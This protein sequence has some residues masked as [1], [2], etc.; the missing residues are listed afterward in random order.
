M[1][2]MMPLLVAPTEIAQ[3]L[4]ET[5]VRLRFWLDSL[6]PNHRAGD[7][8]MSA[9]ESSSRETFAPELCAASP[10]QMAGLLS[11]LMR[12]GEA[13]RVL[14]P[15]ADEPLEEEL[16]EYRENVEQLRALMPFI[17][18]ALLRERACIEQERARVQTAA[19]WAHASRQTL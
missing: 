10:E 9:A 2:R 17:H 6:I 19:E 7:G 8:K 14:P 13:L 5:N 12:A 16:G 1:E 18:S 3:T 11:E 4:H 15:D